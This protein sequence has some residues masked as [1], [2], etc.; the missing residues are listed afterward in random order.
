MQ[1]VD[2][3]RTLPAV[4]KVQHVCCSMTGELVHMQAQRRVAAQG[5]VVVLRS[6]L[7]TSQTASK[8]VFNTLMPHVTLVVPV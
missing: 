5:Q 7:T 6:Q 3:H 8:M 2:I 4:C 1:Q